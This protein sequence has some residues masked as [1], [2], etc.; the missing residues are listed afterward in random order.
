M[1]I[2]GRQTI[3]A[4]HDQ[5]WAILMEN[6][7][8]SPSLAPDFWSGQ[9]TGEN[10]YQGVLDIAV[11]PLRGDY[12]CQATI[13]DVETPVGFRIDFVGQGQQGKVA[14]YGRIHLTPHNQNTTIHYKGEIEADDQLAALAPR[15]LQANINAVIRRACDGVRRALGL[16]PPLSG[17]ALT[18]HD[19]QPTLGPR[20]LIMMGLLLVGTL[21]VGNKL[22]EK[23]HTG[24]SK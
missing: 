22:R 3:A 18:H 13:S 4:P 12:T 20:T 23:I 21:I 16:E 15:L 2:Q 11:G 5:V 1:I 6:G 10:S 8:L 17:T 9:T 19:N 24:K 7:R 14:G